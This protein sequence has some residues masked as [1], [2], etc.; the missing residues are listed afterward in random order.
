MQLRLIFEAL[1]R[2]PVGSVALAGERYAR[3]TFSAEV[4][5]EKLSGL[6]A[7]SA[8][9]LSY[10]MDRWNSI[11]KRAQ[12]QLVSEVQALAAGVDDDFIGVSERVINPALADLGWNS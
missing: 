5:A 12:K 11:R 3:S 6:L 7:E 8:P 10:V 2:R 4:V 9:D 1:A